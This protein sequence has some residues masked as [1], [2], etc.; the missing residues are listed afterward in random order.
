MLPPLQ[1]FN[2]RGL[3]RLIPSRFS[4]S[5]TVLCEIADNADML[6][7][8]MLLDGATNDRIQGEHHGLS[9]ITPY[10]LVYGI[11]NAHIVRAAFLHPSPC[12]SRFNDATRGAWY[13]ALKL[14]TSLAEVAFH[15]ALH[16]GEIVVP[17]LPH[18]RPDTE[19]SEYDD[20]QADFHAAFHSLDPASAY[21]E[22]LQPEPVP[23][24]YA[25]PQQLARRLLDQRSNGI[26]YPSVRHPGGLCLVCF[27]PPLVYNP[28]QA[29]RYQITLTLA[30]DTYSTRVRTVPIPA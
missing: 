13:A 8:V 14:D 12:G 27:R 18:Q 11:P 26:L 23:Q 5:G 3:H 28:R 30:G 24:C 20:W 22:C 4:D 7:D 9:G 19:R 21:E 16:L 6:A 10:E 25:A 1:P 2:R 29:A 17:E 15:R